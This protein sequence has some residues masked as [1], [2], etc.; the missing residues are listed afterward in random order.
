VIK[1]DAEDK[2]IELEDIK[3]INDSDS[4]WGVN[5]VLVEI[6]GKEKLLSRKIYDDIINQLENKAHE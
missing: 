5:Y 3:L 1:E 4:T 2:P 6:R